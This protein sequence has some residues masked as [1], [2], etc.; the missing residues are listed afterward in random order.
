VV[1]AFLNEVIPM[2]FTELRLMIREYHLYSHEQVVATLSAIFYNNH[3]DIQ[4][5]ELIH[6]EGGVYRSHAYRDVATAK[7]AIREALWFIDDRHLRGHV[8]LVTD[9]AS[10][11]TE[12]LADR[13]PAPL[14][15]VGALRRRAL[16]NLYQTTP[17]EAERSIRH[18]ALRRLDT[19]F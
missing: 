10:L 16:M 19:G 14:S 4:H 9:S 7:R 17:E 11:S 2:P 12:S 13:L 1:Q 8:N 15:E 6:L 5:G 18:R 3:F